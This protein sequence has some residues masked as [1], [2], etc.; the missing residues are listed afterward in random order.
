MTWSVTE[1]LLKWG[2]VEIIVVYCRNF[3]LW[4]GSLGLFGPLAGCATVRRGGIPSS[5]RHG[6]IITHFWVKQND[7]GLIKDSCISFYFFCISFVV[8]Y[9]IKHSKHKHSQ[10]WPWAKRCSHRVGVKFISNE[11]ERKMIYNPAECSNPALKYSNEAF[12]SKIK[13]TARMK[14]IHL[15]LTPTSSGRGKNEKGEK[16]WN[17]GR[18]H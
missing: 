12:L 1:S 4:C 16:S 8:F 3:R 6:N 14:F 2:Q 13:D 5:D 18:F 15:R 9:W 11:S 17:N 7:W 10:T